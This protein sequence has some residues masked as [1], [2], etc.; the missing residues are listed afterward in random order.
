[1][2]VK[3]FSIH[4]RLPSCTSYSFI[5]N[6]FAKGNSSTQPACIILISCIYCSPLPIHFQYYIC[7]PSTACIFCKVVEHSVPAYIIMP[8]GLISSSPTS[9][10]FSFFHVRV[11]R[12]G[13]SYRAQIID[14][15]VV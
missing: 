14:Y 4:Q 6:R 9:P 10:F 7:H 5:L 8:M 3:I 13:R 11:W 2:L 12:E 1:M 15:F